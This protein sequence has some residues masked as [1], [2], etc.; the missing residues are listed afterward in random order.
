M[1]TGGWRAWEGC[2]EQRKVTA[3]Q[4]DGDGE[5]QQSGILLRK[6]SGPDG[7]GAQTPCPSAAA[8]GLRVTQKITVVHGTSEIWR[9]V[10]SRAVY[11]V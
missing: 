9:K 2:S 4:A 5:R 3:G 7:T 6:Q 11:I 8:E 10:K 1:K